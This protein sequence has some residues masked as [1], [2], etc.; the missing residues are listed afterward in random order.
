MKKKLTPPKK[1]I[2]ARKMAEELTIQEREDFIV[3][4]YGVDFLTFTKWAR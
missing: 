2:S 3:E 1:H 4:K